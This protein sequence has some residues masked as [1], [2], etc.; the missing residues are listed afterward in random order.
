[1]AG[2]DY[3]GDRVLVIW[4][5]DIVAHFSSHPPAPSTATTRTNST[6]VQIRVDDRDL[7]VAQIEKQ[8][9][10][11]EIV[12]IEL[13]A[14]HAPPVDIVSKAVEH[15]HEKK[16]Q[17]T[18]EVPLQ[19][20][21]KEHD[22]MMFSRIRNSFIDCLF[23]FSVGQLNMIHQSFVCQ[24][25]KA[26]LRPEAKLLSIV[27]GQSLDSVK[28]GKIAIPKEVM[29]IKNAYNQF[30]RP[31]F[32]KLK[33]FPWYRCTTI[34]G[35]LF[36]K[37]HL[38]NSNRNMKTPAQV[39][40][41]PDLLSPGRSKFL[42]E[43][44]MVFQRWAKLRGDDKHAARELIKSCFN[45]NSD[46]NDKAS[47]FYVAAYQGRMSDSSLLDF[48]WDSPVLRRILFAMKLNCSGTSFGINPERL[49]TLL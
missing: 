21:K 1:M 31:H 10:V 11:K 32:N 18:D 39:T 9:H 25:P 27:C 2:G 30:G 40:L 17:D 36:D 44:T 33:N 24:S 41:D 13:R 28:H 34:E 7:V 6:S 37:C 45:V 12:E 23:D 4:N 48:P 14:G 26:L 29:E 20:E 35:Q 38:T 43:A 22:I 47:A 15:I 42:Q 46:H 49:M 8:S 5:Q 16:K 3:D 19:N